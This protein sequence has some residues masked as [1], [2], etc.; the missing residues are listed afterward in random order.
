MTGRVLHLVGSTVDHGG[1]LAVLRNVQSADP[2]G[3]YEHVVWVHEGFEQVREPML[4]LVRTR[5]DLRK[6]LL[7]QLVG[8]VRE[9]L[10]LVEEGGFS[11]VHAHDRH[12]HVLGA[13]VSVVGGCRVLGSIH[14]YAKRTWIY[15]LIERLPRFRT[16]LLTPEMARHYGMERAGVPLVPDCCADAFFDE[17]LEA[18]ETVFS[19][20]RQLRLRGF[21]VLI[22]WKGWHVLLEALG[23]LSEDERKLVDV[24]VVGQPAPVESARLYAEGLRRTVEVRGLGGCVRFPG[25][26]ADV[27]AKLREADWMV[28]PSVNEPCAVATSEALAMGKPVLVTRSG[29]NVDTVCE[30]ENGLMFEVG[31]A[32]GLAEKIRWILAGGELGFDAAGIRESARERSA[33]FVRGE[34]YEVYRAWS[35][36]GEEPGR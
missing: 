20:G 26:V 17:R 35:L 14:F 19:E 12:A 21:G 9:L 36:R 31:E 25:F 16:V 2:V 18:V 23:L 34:L 32:A 10:R 8:T 33:S 29:G 22:E 13:V 15:R 24:E 7:K 11:V 5:H 27:R 4:E 30:G 6:S 3:M 1:V 28:L